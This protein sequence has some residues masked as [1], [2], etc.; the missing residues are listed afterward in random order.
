MV[1]DRDLDLTPRA[2][3]VVRPLQV[4]ERDVL[5]QHRRPRA[6]RGVADLL[7]VVQHRQAAAHGHRRDLRRQADRGVE[8]L[9]SLPVD[10]EADDLPGRSLARLALERA[11]AD[12]VAR[13]VERD[14]PAEAHLVG[15]GLLAGDPRV[16]GGGVVDVEHE[17]PRLDA[18]HVHREDA[19][20]RRS[21]S[22]RRRPSA[23]PRRAARPPRPSRSRSRGRRCSRCA[24]SSPAVPA[25]TFGAMRKNLRPSTV[26]LAAAIQD[27]A[28]LRPLQ[29]QRGHLVGALGDRDP[30][31]D[32]VHR[33][34]SAA[35]GSA[36]VRRKLCSPRR[37]TVPSSSSLPSSSHQPV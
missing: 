19:A 27:R 18:R 12:E 24:R 26:V 10:L 37:V 13:L 22:R 3:L 36:E 7:A 25:S 30:H 4:R 14:R 29:A 20:R 9:E 15:R 6:R 33:A 35:T 28:R 1:L 23:R 34:A 2:G 32:R 16:R 5:L 17:Q 11:A 31:A 21:R 8:A